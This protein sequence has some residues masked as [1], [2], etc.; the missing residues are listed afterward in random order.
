MTQHGSNYLRLN[1]MSM[2]AEAQ[3]ALWLPGDQRP[4]VLEG[5]ASNP[6]LSRQRGGEQ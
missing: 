2:R 5:P 4:T 1:E 6:D 3:A